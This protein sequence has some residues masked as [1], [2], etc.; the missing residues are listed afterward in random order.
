MKK[1]LRLLLQKVVLV[2][3]LCFFGVSFAMADVVIDNGDPQTSFTGSWGISGGA[4]P[5]DPLDPDAVSLWS[6]NGNTYT[7][8]F[9]ATESGNHDVSMW[10]TEWPSRGSSIPVS[11]EHA[12]GTDTVIINQKVNGGRW[13]SIGSFSFVSGLSYAITI[14]AVPGPQS[15][16]ADAVRFVYNDGGGNLSPVATIDS[17]APSPAR[18]NELV[19]FAGYGDDPD[20]SISGYNW[21]SD[22]DGQ[23][24]DQASFTTTTPLSFGTHNIFFTVYDNEGAS[25]AAATQQL[26][27]QDT[28]TEWIIDNGDPQ[29]SFTGSWGVS[30][31]S[32]PWRPSDPDAVSLWSRNGNTYTWTFT[33]AE[34]GNHDVSMWWTGW[35]SRGESIPVSIEH[36]DG[37]DTV[38]IN[39]MVNSGKWN[40][41]GSYSFV[42]GLSYAITITAVP[43][44][45]STCADAVRFVYTGGVGNLLPVAQIDVITPPAAAPGDEITF[46]G[47]GNDSDG[48]VTAYMW[49][50]DIDGTLSDLEMF[51]TNLLSPGKHTIY[52]KVMDDQNAWSNNATAF[53]VVRDCQS[54]VTIMPLGNS[55][56]FGGYGDLSAPT[57]LAKGYRAPLHGQLLS[58]GYYIDF[59][60]NQDDGEL[61]EPPF[62]INHQGIRGIQADE[63]A[64]DVYDWLLENP[65]EII[66]LHIGTNGLTTSPIQV[67]AILDEIDRYEANS[68]SQVVVVLAK[69]INRQ[70]FSPDTTV[71]NNNIQAMAEARIAAGDK[72]VVVDQE[73]VLNY[74]TDMADSIHPNDQGYAKMAGP[75]MDELLGLLPVC[76][77][78][79]PF[80]FTTSIK[81]VPLGS[82]YTYQVAALGNPAA[83]FSLLTAPEGMS[84]EANTGQI[85][86]TPAAGQLGSHSVS[87]EASSALGT[88]VQSFN[89]DVTGE[90]III[91]N[92][93]P[94]TS[95]T[96]SW[97]V[98]GGANP[99]NP[100]DPSAISL[101]S[102]NG[103]TYTWTFTPGTS[104]TYQFSMWWTVWPS[105]GENI[106]V[107][108]QH[109]GGEDTIYINQ[110]LNGGQWNG[111]GSFDFISGMSYAV[112]ITSLPGPQSTCADAVRFVKN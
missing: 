33:P 73:S 4:N 88:D 80:I 26:V 103:N 25:S 112:T 46:M 106:P 40:S 95:F 111:L 1:H 52:F 15:T 100:A 87:V 2:L 31:G 61:I 70:P 41:L 17:I 39:Q 11:I 27:V 96:G 51:S 63:V 5:W 18:T 89:V 43:G 68:G 90:T 60:G 58:D 23:L 83:S 16:C 28:L 48:T 8:T 59:V 81:S 67:S 82:I 13:N 3:M 91:D 92:G 14:T 21:V 101:W 56:T 64:S 108:V 35:P 47:T 102:R 24:S 105:R 110:K 55:I 10:W 29:T 57:E 36:A 69:I 45:Q 19:S 84:I 77:T 32:N 34:S 22:I 104:G 6:R 78:V 85:S 74:A 54:P 65:A 71:F 12:S 66:L 98:S 7:W 30:S 79:K 37:T 76:S 9:T 49:E 109:D 86:W 97:G 107:S 75:W 50:S 94:Q 53:V 20:G 72:I 42:S 38:Y 93:D 62:D 44:P 99:W